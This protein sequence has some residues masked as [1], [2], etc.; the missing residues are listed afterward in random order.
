MESAEFLFGC[1]ITCY[2]PHPSNA[3]ELS[4]SAQAAELGP[5]CQS[6]DCTSMLLSGERLDGCAVSFF[7]PHLWIAA[8]C[9]MA[10]ACAAVLQVLDDPLPRD[11]PRAAGLLLVAA[12]AADGVWAPA[13]PGGTLVLA[14]QPAGAEAQPVLLCAAL[15]E[16]EAGAE[17]ELWLSRAFVRQL[18]LAAGRRVLV[19]PVRKPPCLGWV[20][21]GGAAAATGRAPRG[22]SCSPVSTVLVRRGESLPGSGLLVLEA[23]PALQGLLSAG[24]RLTVTE[25]RGGGGESWGRREPSQP[26]LV[27]AWARCGERLARAERGHPARWGGEAGETLWVTRSCLH[28][29]GLFQGEWVSVTRQ[30]EGGSPGSGT[31]LAAVRTFP[32]QWPFPHRADGHRRESPSLNETVLIPASLAFNLSCDPLDGSL[33][34]IQ[35]GGGARGPSGR[36][37]TIRSTAALCT[38]AKLS[39]CG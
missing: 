17:P 28:S 30:E 18:G 9:S 4:N 31:H 10:A 3:F 32:P 7:S 13:G 15:L 23:R 26:P 11:L 20:L 27:S 6:A 38:L 33:L 35:V 25:L 2:P 8:R 34:K 36:R 12:P 21:L 14:M 1:G 5:A 39:C 16:A 24:T 19:W 22:G 37:G 29:L